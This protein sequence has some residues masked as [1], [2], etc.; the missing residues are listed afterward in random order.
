M[1]WPAYRLK[2]A[3]RLRH[4]GLPD[5]LAKLQAYAIH[6]LDCRLRNTPYRSRAL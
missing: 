1:S 6:A 4:Q 2:K 5:R 3:K